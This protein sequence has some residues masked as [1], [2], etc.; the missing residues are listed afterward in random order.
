VVVEDFDGRA[1]PGGV[2]SVFVYGKYVDDF[3]TVDKTKIA[4]MCLGAVTALKARVVQELR[5]C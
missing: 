2:T 4:T 3:L 5:G 1:M